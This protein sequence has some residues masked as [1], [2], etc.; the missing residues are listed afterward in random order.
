MK[1]IIFTLIILVAIFSL[2]PVFPAKAVAPAGTLTGSI[3]TADIGE[4]IAITAITV[5]DAGAEILDATDLCIRIPAAVNAN[6]DTDDTTAAAYGGTGSAK[7]STAVTYPVNAKMLK[8]DI[9]ADFTAGQTLVITGLS[10]VGH[11]A[12]SGAVA[13]DWS[14]DNTNCTGT[15]LAGN[16]NTQITVADAAVDT[17][18]AV[19]T[20]LSNSIGGVSANHTVAFTVPATGV[21][22]DDG[23]I[24]VTFPAGFGVAGA[25]AGALTGIDGT[26]ALTVAAQVVTL[27][28]QD[29]GTNSLAGAKSVVINNVINPIAAGTST[30]TVRTDTTGDELLATAVSGSFFIHGSGS[31]SAGGDVVSD[32]SS[33][34]STITVPLTGIN[35]TA[36]NPYTIKGTA[37][38]S[39][40]SLVAKVELSFDGGES[41]EEAKLEGPI[42]NV[43]SWEYIWQNPTEGNYTIKSRA[44]DDVGNIEIVG[45]EVKITVVTLT[46]EVPTPEAP[47]LEKPIIEMTTQEL[48]TKIVEIQQKIIDLL[49]QLIQL[50]QQEILGLSGISS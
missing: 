8:I 23:N 40:G 33:P 26:V 9:T 20:A 6:W 47:I 30:L 25:T 21:I 43:F 22:T 15:F 24:K 41:W 32:S 42:A 46:S 27:A 19:T 45:G 11:T 10:Y 35:I 34:I 16:A 44:T 4:L 18:T 29:D 36:G 37:L 28:R 38:D 7:A 2:V 12:A 13:L 14:V 31:G 17:L 39:G 1:K 5:T 3:I 50:L 49:A 48:E